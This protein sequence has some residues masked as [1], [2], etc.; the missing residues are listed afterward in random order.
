MVQVATRWSG[1]CRIAVD[2]KL[3]AV[4]ARD[5][6]NERRRLGLKFDRPTEVVNAVIERRYVRHGDP[7]STPGFCEQ[8][9][10][11]AGGSITACGRVVNSH[12]TD[13]QQYEEKR[14]Y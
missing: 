1:N 8:L 9:R 11:D 6:N 7:T 13:Q 14:R 4:I 12:D 2:E 5:V 10:V 3:I